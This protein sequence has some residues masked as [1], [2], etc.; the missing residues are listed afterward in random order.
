MTGARRRVT[1][2]LAVAT[3]GLVA[4]AA[5]GE[6]VPM[7]TEGEGGW[8]VEPR[9]SESSDRPDDNDE[10]ESSDDDTRA[11]QSPA[12]GLLELAAFVALVFVAAVAG[13]ALL[14]RARGIDRRR[15]LPSFP[16][17]PAAPS[18]DDLAEAVEEGL[19]TLEVGA[20]DDAIIACWVRLEEAAAAGGV[21]RLPSE[22]ATELTVRLLDRFD[23]PEAAVDRLLEL[24]RTARYSHHRLGEDDRAEAVASLQAV[25]VAMER[26]VT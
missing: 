22:T 7:A 19:A 8:L 6:P 21:D 20:V 13:R 24:Y 14:R 3:L 15:P 16:A 23:V 18:P 10:A 26:V 12:P 2:G 17:H 9:R 11:P 4:L 5:T 25:G 1:I